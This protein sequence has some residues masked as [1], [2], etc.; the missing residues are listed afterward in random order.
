MTERLSPAPGHDASVLVLGRAG[1]DLYPSVD[2]GEIED[3]QAFTTDVGGSAGN[4]AIGLA[5]HGISVGLISALSGDAVGRFVRRRLEA[6]GVDLKHVATVEGDPRTS[7]AL[8]EVRDRD[9]EVVIYRNNA[10]DLQIT[11]DSADGTVIAKAGYLIVTGTALVAEPSRSAALAWMKAARDAQAHVLLDLD[12]RAYSWPDRDQTE[13]IYM[14]AVLLSDVLVGNDEEFALIAGGQ[15]IESRL[16]E[17]AS[18][19]R[20]CILKRGSNGSVVFTG[21]HEP[22]H[23]GIFPVASKK[24]YGAGDAFLAGVVARLSAGAALVDAVTV[25]SAAAAIVV[26]QRGCAAAMPT[27]DQIEKFIEANDISEA[28]GQDAHQT[29]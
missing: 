10:A 4:I 3:A 12:Y 18:Q 16:S 22:E 11:A 14:Q 29:L 24:P 26:S 19:G 7:L 15:S 28:R 5:R 6:A 13:A 9:C 1:M 25:G 23:I 2:G 20:I 8:A 27:P 17:F 21:A